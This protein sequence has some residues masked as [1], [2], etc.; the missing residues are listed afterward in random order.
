MEGWSGGGKGEGVGE[1]RGMEWGREGVWR[2]GVGEGGRLT[3][4]W[5][6]TEWETWKLETQNGRLRMKVRE[7]EDIVI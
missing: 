5:E 3:E 1:G 7:S 6:M 4:G 2:D